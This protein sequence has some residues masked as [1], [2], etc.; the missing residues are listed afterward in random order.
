MLLLEL[1]LPLLQRRRR[2]S[3]DSEIQWCY[4]RDAFAP[5]STARSYRGTSETR[6]KNAWG[7]GDLP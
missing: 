5:P 1:Q 3:R 7:P 4:P 6:D 2:Q